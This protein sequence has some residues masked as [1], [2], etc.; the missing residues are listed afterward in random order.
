MVSK[1]DFTRSYATQSELTVEDLARLDFWVVRC[2]C[3]AP[4]CPG[5]QMHHGKILR[6]WD[7]KKTSYG[8]GEKYAVADMKFANKGLSND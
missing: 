3:G 8:T 2:D 5:W 6:R 4:N 1:E 7:E